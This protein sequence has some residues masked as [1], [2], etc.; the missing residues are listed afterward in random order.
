MNMAQRRQRFQYNT[1]NLDQRF[2][3][4]IAE[5]TP[6]IATSIKSKKRK[7]LQRYRSNLSN[8]NIFSGLRDSESYLSDNLIVYD[9][10]NHFHVV[11]QLNGSIWPK[12]LPFCILN[13]LWAALIWYLVHCRGWN[14]QFSNG[15]NKYLSALISF[16]VV[17]RVRMIYNRCMVVRNLLTILCKSCEH[18]VHTAVA[19]TASNSTAR[20][21]KW[22]D[23]V[24]YYTIILLKYTVFAL[25][26][27]SEYLEFGND[28]G[29]CEITN[30]NEENFRIPVQL[31][32]K[33][34]NEIMKCKYHEE[35]KGLLLPPEQILA[36][37]FVDEYMKAFHDLEGMVTTPFPFPIVQMARS[38]L[39]VWLISLPFG[40][41]QDQ[42]PLHGMC[43]MVFLLTFGFIGLE[44]VSIEMSDPFGIDATDFDI[45]S[46]AEI[47]FEDIYVTILNVDGKNASEAL[48]HRVGNPIIEAMKF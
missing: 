10:R 45:F 29:K 9:D 34:R 22:R 19:L 32:Y 24:A 27:N 13:T 41:V 35:L 5:Q 18:L 44:Y 21:K 33:L 7:K 28:D 26:F 2:Q 42:Y 31:A 30:M 48:H 36:I 15:G 6:S 23:H 25:H 14:F 43:F 11:T 3:S 39:F 17:A 37:G 1:R 20:A 8:V 47:T 40:L 46:M 4:I 12:V 16:V 38:S